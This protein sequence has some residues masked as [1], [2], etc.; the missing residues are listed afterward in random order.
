M[1]QMPVVCT[2][3]GPD[4]DAQFDPVS[5]A[6]GTLTLNYHQ[7]F[8]EQCVVYD[9]IVF[10]DG[11]GIIFA[12]HDVDGGDLAGKNKAYFDSYNVVC[13]KLVVIGGK[14]P[15]VNNPCRPDDP[16]DTYRDANVITWKDRLHAGADG[17]AFATAAPDGGFGPGESPFDP[18][19]WSN[20][21][22][23]DNGKKGQRGQDGAQGNAGGSGLNILGFDLGQ[24][25][26]KAPTLTLVAL[27]VEFDGAGSKLVLDWD[28]Q[29]AGNGG[30]GQNGGAGGD[31]MGGRDGDTDESVWGDSCERSPGNGGNAG[32]GGDG[33]RG[34]NGGNG[35]TAGRIIVISRHANVQPGG[36]LFSSQVNYINGGASGGDPGDGGRGGRAAKKVGRAGKKTSECEAAHDGQAGADGTPDPLGSGGTLPGN[37][38]APGGHGGPPIFEVI[39]PPHSGTC[40]DAIPDGSEAAPL[41]VASITPTTGARGATVP[42]SIVGTGFTAAVQVLV[43]GVGISVGALTVTPTLITCSFTIGAAAPQN[44]RDVTVRL[45]AL[46][47]AT[48]TGGFTVS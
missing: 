41:S 36:P 39:D 17:Q 46:Q 6:R 32:D 3:C 48:L 21:G 15:P 44:T 45:S 4:F 34:G 19:T 14:E 5:G 40:A 18:N 11:G 38:G 27:E 35:G 7:E 9:T 10:Y 42:V 24:I 16:G 33:G 25:K 2:T 43:S 37:P 30:R 8:K 47:Q 12:P 22:Q 26:E 13:R 31:G 20:Q 1:S 23:G 28:G 29:S